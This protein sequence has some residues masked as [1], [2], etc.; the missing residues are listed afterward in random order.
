MIYSLSLT[1][2]SVTIHLAHYI[3]RHIL[4]VF[5]LGIKI[6]IIL[7]DRINYIYLLSLHN[8]KLKV[9]TSL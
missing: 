7:K 1:I 6:L 3:I 9:S 4:S 2:L 5:F 8:G